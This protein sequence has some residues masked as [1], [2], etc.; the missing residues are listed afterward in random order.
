MARSLQVGSVF[1]IPLDDA[2][3]GVGQLV[4]AYNQ[5]HYFYVGV[6]RPAYDRNS[7]PPPASA[8]VKP[9]ALLALTMDVKITHGDWEVIGTADVAAGTPL[10]AYKEAVG[11][12]DHIDVVDFSGTMRRRATD[13][14]ASWLPNRTIVHQS[15]SS[16]PLPRCTTSNRGTTSSPRWSRN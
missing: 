7:V 14:E 10:P 5:P 11:T 15:A 6:F 4:A 8:A 16:L 1:T 2:R 3:V 12:F 13:L 9:L